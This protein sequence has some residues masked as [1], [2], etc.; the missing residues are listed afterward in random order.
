MAMPKRTS[1]IH[2]A[3]R[4]SLKRNVYFLSNLQKFT[5]I[6]LLSSCTLIHQQIFR[7]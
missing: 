3:H 5:S 4:L 2:H 7:M 1:C 6:D